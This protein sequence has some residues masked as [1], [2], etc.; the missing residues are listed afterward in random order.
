L[1]FS[2]VHFPVNPI[3]CHGPVNSSQSMFQIYKAF[4]TI[5]YFLLLTVFPGGQTAL[6]AQVG[7]GGIPSSKEFSLEPAE[8]ISLGRPYERI[9][10][11]ESDQYNWQPPKVGTTR[12]IK[13]ELA[14]NHHLWRE[15]PGGEKVWILSVK[16]EG[17][18]HI[19]LTFH[20]FSL[21]PGSRLFVYDSKRQF[22]LGSF[23][24]N[25]NTASEIFTV[26]V[27][28]GDEIIVELT[29]ISDVAIKDGWVPQSRF[30]IGDVGHFY[31]LQM[32]EKS[33]GDCMIDINCLEGDNW[34]REKRGVTRIVLKKGNDWFVCSGSLVNNTVND[35]TGLLLSAYHCGGDASA[36]DMQQWIFYFNY[37]RSSCGSLLKPSNQTITGATLLAGTPIKDNSDFMIL[38][39]N[40]SPPKS[41]KPY[42]NGWDRSTWAPQSGVGIHHPKGDVKKISTFN[43]T[44]ASGTFNDG[45]RNAYWVVTWAATESGHGVTEGGSSGSPLF[46]Q[47]KRIVGTL[48]GG[49]SS[50]DSVFSPDYFGKMRS[51]WNQGGTEPEKQLAFW[52]DPLFTGVTTLGGFDPWYHWII[53]ETRSGEGGVLFSSGVET[54]RAGIYESE[55]GTTFSMTV[56]PETGWAFD[57]WVIDGIEV[58]DNP[59]QLTSD[60]DVFVEVFFRQSEDDRFTITFQVLDSGNGMIDNAYVVFDGQT[61]PVGQYVLEGIEPGDYYFSV[62]HP[63]YESFIGQM[64]VTTN[65]TTIAV[66]LEESGLIV[67]NPDI[68]GILVYPNPAIS[69]LFVKS[70]VEIRTIRIADMSGRVIQQSNVGKDEYYFSV[71]TFQNGVY[72]LHIETDLGNQVRKFT[73]LK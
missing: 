26:S 57:K 71:A 63:G 47:N 14:D 42:F 59:L 22:V 44:P 40:Q 52:L 46:N 3:L 49:S 73:I 33:T 67:E 48:T 30:T 70:S 9:L 60:K 6:R 64:S 41:Y 8:K 19:N 45:F 31:N 10:T 72:L 17:A 1:Q 53:T 12:N 43:N 13:I 55:K 39:L 38:Q 27:V 35:G 68:K 65:N 23:N 4:Y 62:I 5:I 36:E 50:C 66:V 29:E 37:E 18:S 54:V 28:P 24:E 15:M 58:F 34:Q 32:L 61:Y 69:K 56:S 7:Y 16:S 25:S 20:D 2:G 11:R 51:H 21:S